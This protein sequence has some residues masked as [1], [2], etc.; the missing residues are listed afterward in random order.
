MQTDLNCKLSMPTPLIISEV[1]TKIITYK[2]QKV[3]LDSDVASLYGVETKHVNQAVKNNIEKFPNNYIIEL[4][5]E[6]WEKLRSKFLTTKYAMT[7]VLPKAFTE[8]GLYMLATI[9][10]SKKATE[11]TIAIVEAFAKLRSLTTTLSEINQS[12]DA[13]K[14]K[15]LMN[16]SGEMIAD[17]LD[18]QLQITDTETT[19]ELNFAIVKLKH[20]IKRK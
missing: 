19:I 18:D 16:R 5:Y 2:D 3:I 15:E 13:K 6:E 1:E 7:R 10:K 8:K 9:L 17:F 14:Q 20:T 4:N 12:S 11:T